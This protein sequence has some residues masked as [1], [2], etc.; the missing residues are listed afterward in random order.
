MNIV[1]C[2]AGL[3]MAPNKAFAQSMPSEPSSRQ[4]ARSEKVDVPF[5]TNTGKNG[6]GVA[7]HID[8]AGAVEH[9]SGY[10]LAKLTLLPPGEA[11][12]K[13]AIQ[14]SASYTIDLLSNLSGGIKRGTV[15]LGKGDAIAEIDGSAFG[16]DGATAF[17]DIQFVHGPGFSERWVGDAQVVSNIEAVDA[18]RPLEAWIQLPFLASKAYLKAG[19]IDLNGEFDV[20][21][22]GA[23]FINSSHGIGPDFSQSGLNGP[24]IFPTT[25]GAVL[26]R[27]TLDS[28]SGAIGAFDA[29]AGDPK[30][31]RRTRIAYPGAKGALFVAEAERT[32]TEKHKLKAGAWIYTGKFDMLARLD[33][34]GN[35]KRISGNRGA[36]ATFEAR[37]AEKGDRTLDGWVRIGIAE[38]E[39]NPIATTL[40]GGIAWGSDRRRFGLAVAH[41]RL[42]YAGREALRNEGIDAKGA[43][44]VIEA[45]YSFDVTKG[46]TI[47]P[48][49]Q[50][51][52]NPSWRPDLDNAMVAGV[53]LTFTLN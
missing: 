48:D 38:A 39:I 35:P 29:V 22:V 12:A 53:R 41:A 23:L 34:E 44:T 4:P 36:Y 25:S 49:I 8:H 10:G 28:W 50:F 19:L 13:S 18:L 21:N 42:G 15:V 17:V 46:V 47:Q 52:A 2:C 11:Q 45:T 3:A 33:G 20:Q 16:I 40:S 43:E 7:A 30:R 24:S 26:L 31:P 14:F 5:V 27:A 37:L 6:P 9:L 51:I 1:L 32:I